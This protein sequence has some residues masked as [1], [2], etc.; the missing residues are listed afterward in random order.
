MVQ[1]H[2]GHCELQEEGGNIHE[3]HIES[4]ISH[5]A[6]IFLPAEITCTIPWLPRVLISKDSSEYPSKSNGQTAA[7]LCSPDSRS[8]EVKYNNNKANGIEHTMRAASAIE[9][10]ERTA[11]VVGARVL[12]SNASIGLVCLSKRRPRCS[13]HP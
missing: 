6:T 2:L 5:S 4:L 7:N 9:I 8:E 11:D 10:R 13:V 3:M 1:D 12:A